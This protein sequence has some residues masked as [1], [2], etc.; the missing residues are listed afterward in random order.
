MRRVPGG[1][2]CDRCDQRVVDFRRMTERE[3][4][5]VTSLFP[6]GALCARLPNVREGVPRFRSEARS[7]IPT[8]L[9]TAVIAAGCSAPTP[10]ATADPATQSAKPKPASKPVDSDG[11]GIP[12]AVDKCPNEPETYN[13]FEDE[14]GCPDKGRVLLIESPIAIVDVLTFDEGSDAITPAMSPALDA[15]AK[16]F[17][18][19]PGLG[20]IVVKGHSTPSEKDAAKLAARRATNV[21]DALVKRGVN[22]ASLTTKALAPG[23]PAKGEPAAKGRRVDFEVLP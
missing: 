16:T 3:A 18:S 15:V 11:D 23:A 19:N 20:T 17:K 12:D 21:L 22:K 9:V 1:R 6:A 13:G 8:L 5:I 2:F 10:I 14:D 7:L 4:V